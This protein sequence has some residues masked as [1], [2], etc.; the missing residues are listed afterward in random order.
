[1]RPGLDTEA[2]R[3]D[4]SAIT[5]RYVA[6]HGGNTDAGFEPQVVPLATQVL[7]ASKDALTLLALAGLSESCQ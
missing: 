4:L 6:E 5:R 7:G 2:T 3:A 1:M